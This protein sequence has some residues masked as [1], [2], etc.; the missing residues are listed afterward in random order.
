MRPAL[1]GTD[2][3]SEFLRGTEIVITLDLAIDWLAE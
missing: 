1:V 2:I 3:L